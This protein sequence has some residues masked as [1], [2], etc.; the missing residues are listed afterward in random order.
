MTYYIDLRAI[1]IIELL[2][3]YLVYLVPHALINS[4]VNVT[5][6]ISEVYFSPRYLGN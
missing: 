2:Q 3:H 1:I 6:K 5:R 4:D